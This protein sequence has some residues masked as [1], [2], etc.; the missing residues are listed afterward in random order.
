MG[1]VKKSYIYACNMH[2]Y[3]P[4]YGIL[5]SSSRLDGYGSERQWSGDKSISLDMHPGTEAE[6]IDQLL[7]PPPIIPTMTLE[8]NDKEQLQGQ[9]LLDG[10]FLTSETGATDQC[11]SLEPNSTSTIDGKTFMVTTIECKYSGSNIQVGDL[12][13]SD[14]DLTIPGPTT[15]EASK[16]YKNESPERV[17]SLQ[18]N[19]SKD[20]PGQDIPSQNI[21]DAIDFNEYTPVLDSTI[22][23]LKVE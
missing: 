22:Q 4:S 1:Y 21:K 12:S 19:I 3:I 7:S 16:T 23:A 10:M 2:V 20:D 17:Y 14:S 18:L 15:V 13:E 11:K 6:Y 9:I 5:V 8:S